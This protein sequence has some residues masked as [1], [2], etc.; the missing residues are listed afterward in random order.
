MRPPF[1]FEDLEIWQLAKALAIKFHKLADINWI[2]GGYTA[3]RNNS[4]PRDY[5][6]QTILLRD[7]EA[8]ILRNSNNS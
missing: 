1:R 7:R 2:N 5:L 6:S 3:T 4:E 8:Y